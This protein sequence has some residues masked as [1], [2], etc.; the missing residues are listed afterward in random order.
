MSLIRSVCWFFSQEGIN[1]LCLVI[2]PM[3]SVIQRIIFLSTDINPKSIFILSSKYYHKKFR[4]QHIKKRY[5]IILSIS[6]MESDNQETK[7]TLSVSMLSTCTHIS[8]IYLKV[9]FCND[10]LICRQYQFRYIKT[11]QGILIYLC[12][13]KIISVTN[14]SKK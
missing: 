4:L 11:N 8:R 3:C 5:R 2:F 7:S 10:L 13:Y 12:Y 6:Q 9:N 14:S 1:R